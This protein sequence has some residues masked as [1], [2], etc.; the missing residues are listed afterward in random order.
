MKAK[1]MYQCGECGDVHDFEDEAIECCQPRV[2][3][4]YVCSTCDEVHLDKEDAE[5]CCPQEESDEQMS[6]PK[7]KDLEAAGQIRL[8]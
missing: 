6:R 4:V 8:F 5:Q 7:P 3:E 2:T 1:T